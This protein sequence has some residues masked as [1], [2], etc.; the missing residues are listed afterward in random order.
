MSVSV[1]HKLIKLGKAF[2]SGYAVKECIALVVTTLAK[3]LPDQY[4][5]VLINAEKPVPINSDT[6]ARRVDLTADKIK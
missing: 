6:V 3:S 4:I 2:S 5:N 1:S